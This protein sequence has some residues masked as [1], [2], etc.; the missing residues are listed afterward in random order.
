MSILGPGHY[1]FG[2]SITTGTFNLT[3][4]S[5]NG[6][7]GLDYDLESEDA[8]YLQ[9]YDEKWSTLDDGNPR[10]PCSIHVEGN[11]RLWMIITGDLTLEIRRAPVIDPD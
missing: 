5:G 10:F 2:K 7:L 6:C 1:K 3:Y 9:F 4:S 11:R 8:Q